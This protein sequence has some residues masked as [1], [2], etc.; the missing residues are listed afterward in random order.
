[1]ITEKEVN[2]TPVKSEGPK[3][4][5]RGMLAKDPD[6]RMTVEDILKDD[7]VT[8]FGEEEIDLKNVDHDEMDKTGKKGFGNLQRL[9]KSKALG[10]G[11][12]VK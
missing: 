8:N 10:Q 7:W 3:N 6:N 4:V 11:A 1:M 5:L 9:L 12:T 2:Y